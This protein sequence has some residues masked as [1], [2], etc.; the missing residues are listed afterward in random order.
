MRYRSG[1]AADHDHEVA[2]SRWV[3]IDEALKML[4]FKKERDVVERAAGIIERL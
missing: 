2:E 4:V 3:A 1:D